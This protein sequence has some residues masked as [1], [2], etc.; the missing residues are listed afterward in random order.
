MATK[1]IYNRRRDL[2]LFACCNDFSQRTHSTRR[3]TILFGDP[4]QH[5]NWQ[6]GLLNF[7]PDYESTQSSEVRTQTL[8]H[9]DQC[10]PPAPTRKHLVK[11][12]I[13]TQRGKLESTPPRSQHLVMPAD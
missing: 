1:N 7:V 3:I 9:D 13:E 6:S 4:M 10:A 8:F 12:C 11:P 5:N 2:Q